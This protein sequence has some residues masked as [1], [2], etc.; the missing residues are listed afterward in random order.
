M[1]NQYESWTDD[2]LE[3]ARVAAG[4]AYQESEDHKMAETYRVIADALA[5]EQAS[6]AHR[7]GES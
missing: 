5:D 7:R 6:R 3:E 2:Q 1:A 4:E